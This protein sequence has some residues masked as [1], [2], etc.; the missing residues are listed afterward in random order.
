MRFSC[1]FASFSVRETLDVVRKHAA[2]LCAFASACIVGSRRTIRIL[3]RIGFLAS[4]LGWGMVLSSSATAHLFY[5]VRSCL[6]GSAAHCAREPHAAPIIYQPRRL[7][8]ASQP[9]TAEGE[10]V[11]CLDVCRRMSE[12]SRL[13]VVW[14]VTLP[15]GLSTLRN[16]CS[17]VEGSSGL[18]GRIGC[19]TLVYWE[20]RSVA[21]VSRKCRHRLSP[22]PP[23]QHAFIPRCVSRAMSL[24]R[25]RFR[26]RKP[27]APRLDGWARC[28]GWTIASSLH[29]TRL[30]RRRQFHRRSVAPCRCIVVFPFVHALSRRWMT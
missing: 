24:G 1:R 20:R 12:S 30:T 3:F 8:Y 17:R 28:D 18:A 7:M 26:D 6:P 25:I 19:S 22:P 10:R 9:A 15:R 27:C 13:S 29:C 23:R 4:R 5:V 11:V 2:Y 14:H 16:G 21:P